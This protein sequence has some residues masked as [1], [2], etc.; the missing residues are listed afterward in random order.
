[1]NMAVIRF[2]IKF[3]LIVF[4]IIFS[5]KTYKNTNKTDLSNIHNYYQAKII[6]LY[7]KDLN[8]QISIKK[9]GHHIK[10]SIGN[11]LKNQ[12]NLISK[13]TTKL[14]LEKTLTFSLFTSSIASI[15]LI[16]YFLT[17]GKTLGQAKH[18]RG[19]DIAT[20]KQLTKLVKNYNKKTLFIP[21]LIYKTRRSLVLLNIL[22]KNTKHNQKQKH[23]QP[24]KLTKNIPYPAH[25]ETQHTIITGGSGTG[26]TQMLKHL[27]TQIRKNGDRAI[28]YDKMGAFIPS[29]Y[30]KEKHNDII[31]NPFDQRSP[32]WSIFNEVEESIY[33]DSIA[34]ALMPISKNISDPFWTQAARTIFTSVASKLKEQGETSNK[35]LVDSLLKIDLTEIGYIR[36]WL[37][38]NIQRP[39]ADFNS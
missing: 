20:A 19:G 10:T 30:N 29:F 13:N 6:S 36:R 5:I 2:I 8:H 18:I 35:K 32:I 23:Y 27:L 38:R 16:I 1:M 17:K 26:K 11:I 28:I 25:T 15:I 31:L 9:N 34:S 3:F 7:Q 24:Y 14:N 39:H 21:N 33:F 12:N 4:I 37:H 22:N